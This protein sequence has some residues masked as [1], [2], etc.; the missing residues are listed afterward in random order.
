MIANRFNFCF[1]QISVE[2]KLKS[3]S[4]IFSAMSHNAYDPYSNQMN[5]EINQHF[6]K[7]YFCENFDKF[8]INVKAI[9]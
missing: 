2:Q 3:K 9:F 4:V 5:G 6:S 7:K 8:R 1:L